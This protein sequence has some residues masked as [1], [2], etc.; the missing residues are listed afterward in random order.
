MSDEAEIGATEEVEVK[1]MMW[2]ETIQDI[3]EER[4]TF[5]PLDI[6][7]LA[8]CQMCQLILLFFEL[9]FA[10]EFWGDD[11]HYTLIITASSECTNCQRLCTI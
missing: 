11:F 3:W 10:K 6:D 2:I 4:A 1:W 5:A 9:I 8:A 7:I